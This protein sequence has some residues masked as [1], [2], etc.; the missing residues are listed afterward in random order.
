MLMV[1]PQMFYVL[2]TTDS[3]P[4]YRSFQI[5]NQSITSCSVTTNSKGSV[6]ALNSGHFL[7]M[8]RVNASATPTSQT[9]SSFSNV[10]H[11]GLYPPRPIAKS[12]WHINKN[13]LSSGFDATKDP[14]T[15]FSAWPPENYMILKVDEKHKAPTAFI[16]QVMESKEVQSSQDFQRLTTGRVYLFQNTAAL[17]RSDLYRPD[18]KDKIARLIPNPY[19]FNCE[20]GDD[21]TQVAS[22]AIPKL[23][24]FRAKRTGR[25]SRYFCSEADEAL[26][27]CFPVIGSYDWKACNALPKDIIGLDNTL[28]EAW[29]SPI[30]QC[31][32]LVHG[33]QFPI[34][35]AVVRHFCRRQNCVAC[36]LNIV[37]SNM[38]TAS[39]GEGCQPIVQMGSLIGVLKQRKEFLASKIFVP[40]RNRDEMVGKLHMAQSLMLQCLDFDFSNVTSAGAATSNLLTTPT[41][42]KAPGALN[43]NSP[44]QFQ[45]LPEPPEMQRIIKEYFGTQL[46]A[47]SPIDPILYWEMPPS[48]A[49]V[50]EGL[51]HVLKQVEFSR[52]RERIHIRALPPV[53][54]ILL[55]PDHG[56]L[57][58]PPTL[59][60]TRDKEV[61]S[62]SLCCQVHHLSDDVDDKGLFVS[63]FTWPKASARPDV[64][65]TTS[66]GS[67]NDTVLINDY[68]VTAP[69]TSKQMEACIPPSTSHSVALGYY[70][71][72]KLTS[73]TFTYPR[74]A[75]P[76]Q[77]QYKDS[78]RHLLSTW[79]FLGPLLVHDTI[80][81][82]LV[83]PTGKKYPPQ[84]F[85][86][87]LDEVLPTDLIAIDAEYVIPTWANQV[88]SFQRKPYYLLARVSCIVSSQPGDER[89]L[90]DDY[91]QTDEDIKD[92]VSQYSGIHHGDLELGKSHY[93]LTT[94]KANNM[95]LR[96]LLDRGCKFVGHGLSQDF[97]VCNLQV[98]AGQT[99]DT[100]ELFAKTKAAGGRKFA[101]RTLAAT[102][103]G[104]TIQED[105][106][107]SIEDARTALRLYRKYAELQASGQLEAFVDTVVCGGGTIDT[108][109]GATSPATIATN[110]VASPS[111]LGKC[112]KATTPSTIAVAT[113]AKSPSKTPS[114]AAADTATAAPSATSPPTAPGTNT[115]SAFARITPP[116]SK[117]TT[118]STLTPPAQF[119]TAN[120]SSMFP[121]KP[122]A[123]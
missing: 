59:T 32:F 71:Y 39:N 112:S 22:I 69:M 37:F 114:L 12:K 88:E 16:R 4:I 75:N 26:Q 102:L 82:Q 48:A 104:E 25:D 85:I 70:S 74:G 103:L 98:P 21:S 117:S 86:K 29:I 64:T 10:T 11:G 110:T 23:K 56:H 68:F 19:P 60:F 97:R 30:V 122:I 17:Q 78:R 5:D 9:A 79:P 31:M 45:D 89:V 50:E 36:E 87:S 83:G 93:P 47:Q 24:E 57:Q 61:Y 67:L 118:P 49:K 76:A 1:T 34:R 94:R 8:S 28:P 101:L 65:Q 115:R 105:E 62:Y 14:S 77:L 91:I 116:T 7:T 95:K 44:A 73:K 100:V 42:G 111:G 121:S 109:P 43:T 123:Q 55:N 120:P 58:P 15:L 46:D 107:D 6:I 51:T 96:A 80:A 92:Y 18:P 38:I 33:P 20:V 27:V 81:D 41:G 108:P 13:D 119:G 106:H 66:G 99:I 84:R 3:A 72:D 35:N 53:L 40:A 54:V 90:V 63:T 2:S 113:P 52:P